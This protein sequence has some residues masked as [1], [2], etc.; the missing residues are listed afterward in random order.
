MGL[1]DFGPIFGQGS[2][3]GTGAPNG[4]EPKPKPWVVAVFAVVSL[5]ILLAIALQFI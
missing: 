3:G 4:K 1:P 2:S 5:I